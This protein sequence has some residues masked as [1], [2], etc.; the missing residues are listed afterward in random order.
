MKYFSEMLLHEPNVALENKDN[1]S[2]VY[3]KYTILKIWLVSQSYIFVPSKRIQLIK[4]KDSKISY[5]G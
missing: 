4:L 1:K 3:F 5:D 2:I